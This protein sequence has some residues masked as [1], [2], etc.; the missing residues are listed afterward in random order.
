MDRAETLSYL[1]LSAKLYG[2][3]DFADP[4]RA[5]VEGFITEHPAYRRS[6]SYAWPTTSGDLDAALKRAQEHRSKTSP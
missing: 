6:R 3:D 1:W 4:I 2:Y 5:T